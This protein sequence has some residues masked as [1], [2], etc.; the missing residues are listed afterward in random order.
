MAVLPHV[1]LVA[2]MTFVLFLAWRTDHPRVEDEPKRPKLASV[3]RFRVLLA[4]PERLPPKGCRR[5]ARC[6]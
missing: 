1:V 3:V 4:T 5:G 6:R 2:G